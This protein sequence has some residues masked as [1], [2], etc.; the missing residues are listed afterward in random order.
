VGIY[1]DVSAAFYEAAKY[2]PGFA[3]EQ[4]DPTISEIEKRVRG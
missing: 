1:E 4:V 2:L 3:L